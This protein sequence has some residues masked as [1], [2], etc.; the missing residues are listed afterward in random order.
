MPFAR[1][2]TLPPLAPA[3]A[4][5]LAQDLG[6]L[7]V[8]H[9]GKNPD[10]TSILIETPSQPHWAIGGAARDTAAHFEVTVTQGTNTEAQKRAFLAAAARALQQALPGL[11]EATYVTIREQPGANW[12]YDGQ[13]QA[14]RAAGRA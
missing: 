3:P 10:L 12:G 8:R 2:T 6:A 1:L 13:S 9:L 5:R 4:A 14:D 7:I 11:A